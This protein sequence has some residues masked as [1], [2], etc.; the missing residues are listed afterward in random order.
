MLFAHKRI[1]M[2]IFTTI[3]LMRI[4]FYPY[5]Y[6][7]P[8]LSSKYIFANIILVVIIS[9]VLVEISHVVSGIK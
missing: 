9:C 8:S 1:C 5:N 2:D 6:L 7:Q 4:L 3:D